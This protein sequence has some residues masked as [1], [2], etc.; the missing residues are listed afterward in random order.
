MMPSE[1]VD[2]YIR[3]DVRQ[4]LWA[5]HPEFKAD[6]KGTEAAGAP[7]Y[8]KKETAVLPWGEGGNGA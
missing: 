2:E 1:K 5:G 6:E 7:P 8:I 3:Q 4:L